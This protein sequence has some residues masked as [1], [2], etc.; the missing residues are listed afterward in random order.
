MINSA[1]FYEFWVL[2]TVN[3][4]HRPLLSNPED[5]QYITHE[6]ECMIRFIYYLNPTLNPTN[7]RL[8]FEKTKNL[9]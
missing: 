3:Y 7:R 1:N 5:I 4:L 2:L 9:L 6:T 8:L